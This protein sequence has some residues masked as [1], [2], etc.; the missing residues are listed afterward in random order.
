MP[1]YTLTVL[2]VTGIQ[3]YVFGSNRVPENVGA[4]QLV[5]QA[6]GAW[7][8]ES[9]NKAKVRHNLKPD[10]TI[11]VSRSLETDKTLDAEVIL[12]GGGNVLILFRILECTEVPECIEVPEFAKATVGKLTRKLLTDAPGLEIAVAHHTFDWAKPVGGPDGAHHELYKKLNQIK[13]QRRISAPLLGLG[14][15]VECRATG[16]PSVAYDEG[17]RPVSAEVKA[18]L[19]R[20]D[21]A[22]KRLRH[23]FAGVADGYAFRNDFGALGGTEGE[24]SYIA[25]VHADG[26]GMGKR[27]EDVLTRFPHAADNRA[28]LNALRD[29]SEA[30]DRAGQT[31]LRETVRRMTVAFQSEKPSAALQ[32]FLAGLSEHDRK[33]VIPFRP[34]LY[35]GDDVTFVCDGRLGLALAAI[36]LEEWERAT[37][38]D[39]TIGQAYACAGVAMVK[40]HYPFVRAYHLA[41]DLCT[42]AKKEIRAARR[43]D[44]DRADA[45]ALDWHFAMSG[46]TGKIG[47]IRT[48][49]YAVANGKMTLRPLTLSA[50]T[51]DPAWRTWATFDLVTRDFQTAWSKRRNKVK[52]LRE[53]LRQGRQAVQDF[54]HAFTL[55]ELPI[56]DPSQPALQES[57]WAGNL[58]GYFDMIEALDFYL[59]L[60]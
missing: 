59:P 25:V 50:Q 40:S 21:T 32:Q 4:S 18:K 60:T 49:E 39:A 12:R 45:S 35:G 29:L 17:K 36:Y 54:R 42:G 52:E 46:I 48:R 15:T 5:H 27:F 58:C 22:D 38:A 9:M 28:C 19:G 44:R 41:S 2:D 24:M 57:G 7:V 33:P 11:D 56:I 3:D 34:I 30:V 53:V 20:Q 6:T 51:F 55:P 47:E 13:Q 26:N 1:E 10:D 23:L 16:M 14:V 31:A 43:D 8:R 37:Q